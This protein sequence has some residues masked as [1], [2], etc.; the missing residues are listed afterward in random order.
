MAALIEVH[1]LEELKRAL[2]LRPRLIGINNRDL[3]TFHVSLETT[4]TLRQRIPGRV[5]VVAESGIGSAEDV[6]RLAVME[7]DAMLVG[8]ALVT[9]SD[10]AGKVQELV[11]MKREA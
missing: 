9:A 1:N 8:E 6:S 7:V 2:Y 4:A 5:T 3:H 10:V 11:G